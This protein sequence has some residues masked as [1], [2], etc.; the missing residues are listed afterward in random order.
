[1]SDFKLGQEVDV[2]DQV[3]R[4]NVPTRHPAQNIS[5]M[6]KSIWPD[7]PENPEFEGHILKYGDIR[8]SRFYG[9][10]IW[11]PLIVL[12]AVNEQLGFLDKIIPLHKGKV[13]DPVETPKQGIV[14]RKR[15]LSNGHADHDECGRNYDQIG[16]TYTAYEVTYSLHR[17]PVICLEKQI[18]PQRTVSAKN[19]MIGS[20]TEGDAR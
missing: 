7:F 5:Q 8:S 18:A 16:K 10:R 15:V 4:I 19:L 2:L 6:I 11:V 20:L 1:M 3:V 12:N 17:R 9:P 14:T 13:Y